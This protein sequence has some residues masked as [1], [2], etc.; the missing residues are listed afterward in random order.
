[1]LI[2]HRVHAGGIF[3]FGPLNRLAGIDHDGLFGHK[4]HRAV[5]IRSF[6]KDT[7]APVGA[8]QGDLLA[9]YRDGIGRRIDCNRF[10]MCVRGSRII[11][12]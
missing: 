5:V 4:L 7:D 3:A 11:C 12:R 9:L 1:M 2:G 10:R 6:L 8:G